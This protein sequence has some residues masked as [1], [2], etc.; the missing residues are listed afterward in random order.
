MGKNYENNNR[1]KAGPLVPYNR[2]TTD[3]TYSVIIEASCYCQTQN[4]L[5]FHWIAGDTR[6][7]CV[8]HRKC[9]KT[10]N[11]PQFLSVSPFTPRHFLPSFLPFAEGSHNRTFKPSFQFCVVGRTE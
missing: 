7:R 10:E 3:S 2:T 5:E 11:N 8:L 4:S 9:T 6:R 1:I